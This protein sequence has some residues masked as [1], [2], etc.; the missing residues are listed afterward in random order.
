MDESDTSDG[1]SEIIDSIRAQCLGRGLSGIKG[2]AVLFRRL[3]I[4]FSKAVVLTEF[5]DGL[6]QYGIQHSVDDLR[7][8]FYY[9]DKN[10][11]GNVDFREFLLELAAP[12]PQ[13]RVDVV[14]EA[15][16]KMDVNRDGSIQ[17]DDLKGKMT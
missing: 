7:R 9:L 2:L 8:V 6:T 5:V 12:M 1:C 15:F 17:L 4:D 13:C 10:N 16:D 14:N 3:D 11:S